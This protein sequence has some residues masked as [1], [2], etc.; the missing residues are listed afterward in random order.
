MVSFF[1]KVEALHRLFPFQNLFWILY[2]IS[3]VL[4]GYLLF[5][6]T[7]LLNKNY[8][9][10]ISPVFGY[11][12]S[13]ELG[14]IVLPVPKDPQDEISKRHQSIVLEY[15]RNVLD[16]ETIDPLNALSLYIDVLCDLSM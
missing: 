12:Q 6:I 1:S 14:Q 16:K 4:S 9:E 15:T 13:N 11:F 7:D 5:K 3:D 2:L 10:L 8:P